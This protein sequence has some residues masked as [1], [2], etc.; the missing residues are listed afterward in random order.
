MNTLLA[1]GLLILAG[2]TPDVAPRSITLN[3]SQ[4]EVS[5]IFRAISMRTGAN[6][7]YSGSDKLPVTLHFTASNTDEAIRGTAAA[8]GLA[9]RRV[10][11]TVIVAKPDALKTALGPFYQRSLI[12]VA[13]TNDLVARLERVFPLMTVLASG[14]EGI[15]ALGLPDDIAAAKELADAYLTGMAA[16][17]DAE[18]ARGAIV[19]QDVSLRLANPAGVIEVLRTLYPNVKAVPVTGTGKATTGSTDANNRGSG[20]DAA[21]DK[22]STEAKTEVQSA[23]RGGTLILVGREKDVL[24]ARAKAL[25]LDASASSLNSET[26]FRVYEIRYGSPRNMVSLMAQMAP[27]VQVAVAP[28]N[29]TLEPLSAG[30]GLSIEGSSTVG[31]APDSQL[32]QTLNDIAQKTGTAE[33]TNPNATST[34]LTRSADRVKRLVLKGRRSDVEAAVSLLSQIDVK[35]AQVVVEVR[36]VDSSPETIDALGIKYDWSPFSVVEA[37]RGTLIDNT[38]LNT[39]RPGGIGQIS[40]LPLGVNALLDL[41]VTKTDTK[42]LANPSIRVIDNE[43][44][45]FFVGNELR[46]AVQTAGPLGSQSSTIEKVLIGVALNVRPRV[47]ADGSIQMLINPSVNAL[48]SVSANG[49]PQVS[50]RTAST[51]LIARDGETIVLGGLI[52]D[53]DIKTVQEVPLLAQLPIV[54]QLFRH[55]DRTHRKSNVVVTIT[56]HIVRDTEGAR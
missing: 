27:E 42:L 41:A 44:A 16:N 23:D 2:Q 36:V 11:R 32:A 28:P 20:T 14:P 22:S 56:P 52:R 50:A 19:T 21:G 35:P 30:V 43:E 54:G 15:Q 4:T 46:Y 3:F 53:E 7:I 17:A 13:A 24:Q 48:L 39:T 9:Y 45:N 1:A 55:T 31:T 33:K 18:A 25:Q 8:A 26:V 5:Q 29:L 51:S 38:F 6:I 37:P 49:L 47:S 34:E 12:H 10:G 40:R